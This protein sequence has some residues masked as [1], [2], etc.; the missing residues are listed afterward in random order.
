MLLLMLRRAH[1][2][3]GIVPA[4]HLVPFPVPLTTF[5]S[6]FPSQL[7][8]ARSPAQPD[9]TDEDHDND[10]DK[11]DFDDDNDD[12]GEGVDDHDHDHDRGGNN[13]HAGN[14]NLNDD[15]IAKDF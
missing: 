6:P 8:N 7:F 15:K 9:D 10:Y 13:L 11:K 14:C 3:L 1:L 4:A 5:R 2:C 12:A